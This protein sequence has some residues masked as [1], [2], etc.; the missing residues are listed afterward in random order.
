M[1][2]TRRG[3]LL[4]AGLSNDVAESLEREH[5]YDYDSRA[6]T[7]FFF[8]SQKYGDTRDHDFAKFLSFVSLHAARLTA[9]ARETVAKGAPRGLQSSS[10]Q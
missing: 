8:Y 6:R 10:G 1:E 2:E 3:C 9:S 4:K 7:P 5:R